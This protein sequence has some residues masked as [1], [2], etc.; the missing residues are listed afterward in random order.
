MR[1]QQRAGAP[2]IRDEELE[3]RSGVA[4]RKKTML[5]AGRCNDTRRVTMCDHASMETCT[6]KKHLAVSEAAKSRAWIQ[7]L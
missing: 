3:A 1:L 2:R 6:A 5:A 4:R 7:L